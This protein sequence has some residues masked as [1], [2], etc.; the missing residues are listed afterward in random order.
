MLAAPYM[1]QASIKGIL[2]SAPCIESLTCITRWSPSDFAFGASDAAVRELI[3]NRGGAFL[4]HPTLH[5]KYYRFDDLILIG[6]ANI[7]ASGLGLASKSNL[8]ILTSPS[9]KFNS[10]A[11]ERVLLSRSRNVTDA[12][13]AV[14]QTFPILPDQLGAKPEPF[15]LPWRPLTRD[16]Q[17]L[18]LVYTG[19]TGTTLT[20]SVRQ[21]AKTDLSAV[22][23][24]PGMDFSLFASWM[25][26]SL[27]ASPFTYEVQS[28][29]KDSEPG[30]FIQLGESW[31]M[32]PG[33]ARY[34][35]E[36]VRN[37]LSFYLDSA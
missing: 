33:D 17:D 29:S 18:W 14:W 6:S 30:A 28:I 9:V 15:V 26:A 27:L 7:T 36:T 23:V 1:K 16:P 2:D 25:T 34:A 22:K 13:F 32:S 11:F 21:Q 5:A 4:L 3:V 37:W 24:P 12:E 19:D 20:A 35:A 8:E 31:N 10:M